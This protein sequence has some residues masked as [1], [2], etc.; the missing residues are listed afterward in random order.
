MEKNLKD[1]LVDYNQALSFYIRPSTF[2]V[3]IKMVDDLAIVDQKAKKPKKD[4]DINMFL[5][6]A[7]NISRR[8][9]W[10]IYLDKNDISCASALFQVE[11]AGGREVLKREHY[12]SGLGK[13]KSPGVLAR[14]FYCLSVR[15]ASLACS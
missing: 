14:G 11:R 15:E 9:G 5:C 10:S 6:Q 3:A 12:R 2:P 13:E 7:I 1:R 8:N 4:L